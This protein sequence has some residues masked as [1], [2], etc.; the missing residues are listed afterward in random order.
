LKQGKDEFYTAW[1]SDNN[2]LLSKKQN[3]G[4]EMIE[5]SGQIQTN[6]IFALLTAATPVRVYDPPP[7]EWR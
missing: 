1:V 3:G 7:R 2:F 5:L 6:A 4:G